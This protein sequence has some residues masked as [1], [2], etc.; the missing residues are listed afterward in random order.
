MWFKFNICRRRALYVYFSIALIYSNQSF[1]VEGG[2]QLQ[3]DHWGSVV[4]LTN[5]RSL[6]S[7]ITIKKQYV[8]TAAHCVERVGD[9]FEIEMQ[10]GT[11]SSTAS[12]S[13][14]YIDPEYNPNTFVG[15]V[16][17]IKLSSPLGGTDFNIQSSEQYLHLLQLIEVPASDVFLAGYGRDEVGTTGFRKGAIIS[18]IG[19]FQH[20]ETIYGRWSPRHGGGSLPGDSGGPVF[21]WYGKSPV[22]VAVVSGDTVWKSQIYEDDED[23]ET[24]ERFSPIVPSLC[25]ASQSLQTSLGFQSDACANIRQFIEEIKAAEG[26]PRE[27]IW[28]AWHIDNSSIEVEWIRSLMFE[29][30][31]DS[32]LLGEDSYFFYEEAARSPSLKFDSDSAL[33]AERLK[34]L[35]QKLRSQFESYNREFGDKFTYSTYSWRLQEW[36]SSRRIPMEERSLDLY[37]AFYLNK[38]EAFE[39]GSV[40]CD[41]FLRGTIGPLESHRHNWSDYLLSLQPIPA[42][43]GWPEI[44]QI[45]CSINEVWVASST[46]IPSIVADKYSNAFLVESTFRSASSKQFALKSESGSISADVYGN[47][48]ILG[49]SGDVVPSEI[50]E[51]YEKT[52]GENGFSLSSSAMG[53]IARGGP[54][55]SFAF[56]QPAKNNFTL[57]AKDG[58]DGFTRSLP[59]YQEFLQCSM[60]DN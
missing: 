23:I 4:K 43:V 46:P 27:K 58:A 13:V 3:A 29:L 48:I 37:S 15:D 33:G 28:T 56:F 47:R 8:L 50:E 30:L 41:Y 6:C 60:A 42:N 44:K 35:D 34:A 51:R 52:F 12:G 24:V 19:I 32:F 5:A 39:C 57:L 53:R 59:I 1:A 25:R 11:F 54:S 14:V 55:G 26:S 21:A 10:Q 17:I 31:L 49:F 7:G 40:P 22:I 20:G 45:L 36:F 9:S 2:Y 38:D 18:G 16:A